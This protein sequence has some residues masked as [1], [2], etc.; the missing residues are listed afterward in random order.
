MNSAAVASPGAVPFLDL[1]SSHRRLEDELVAVF[2]RC[3]HNAAFVGGPEVEAFEREFATFAGA[4]HCLAVNSGTDALRFA[5]QALGVK[6]GDEVITVPNTFIAT[7][8]ALSQAGATLR[9]VDV[10]EQS[11]T[12]DPALLEQAITPRTV[13]IVPVHLYGQPCDLDPI[14]EIALR[15][16]LWVVEDAAQAHGA[17]YKGRPVGSIGALAAWSFY[18]G[19]NLG[20][21]GEGGAVTGENADLLETVRQLREHGQSRKYFHDIEGYNGRLHAIQAGFLRVKLRHL[22]QWN[23]GR[24]R[25]AAKYSR[26]LADIPNIRLPQEEAYA[27]H[28]YHLFVIR[29]ERRDELQQHLAKNGIGTGLHYPLPLH[30]QKAYAHLGLSTGAFPVTERAAHDILS[31]PMFPEL[32]DQQIDRV[33]DA[34]KTFYL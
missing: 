17:R 22:E 31:L 20:S 1:V 32:S 25:A 33:A 29:A 18:P 15:R 21:C 14:M 26:A 8:E 2:R 9:F 4:S 34:I 27:R 16:G 12:M 10:S 7:T 5:Y 13:G 23:D 24:R 3:V 6:P 28:V 19:K 30:L 11:L